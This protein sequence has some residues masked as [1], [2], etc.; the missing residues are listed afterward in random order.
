MPAENEGRP[1]SGP[2]PPR[3]HP[4]SRPPWPW[5]LVLLIVLAGT[6]QAFKLEIN[7]DALDLL[8]GEAVRGDIALLQQ[9]GLVDRLFITLSHD[10]THYPD[11]EAALSALKA[12]AVGV[13]EAMA[14]APLFT[15]VIYRFP[16]DFELALFQ[17]LEPHL[18]TLLHEEELAALAPRL[19]EEQLTRTLETNFARLNSP[20]GFILK[21]QVQRDPLGLMGLVLQKLSHL[22]SGFT[23]SISD[24]FFLSD[25][26]ASI[27]LLAEST[28]SLTDSS[29]AREVARRLTKIMEENLT[30][31]VEWRIIGS[32]PHT[33]A[34][35]D[36]VQRDLRLLLPVATVLLFS[37]LIFT[38]RDWRALL[39]LGIPFL[40]APAAIAVMGMIHG[41]VS[42]LALGFGI[43]LIGIAVDFAVH[44]Y[45]ALV[46]AEG[47][48]RQIKKLLLRPVALATLTTAGVFIILLFSEVPS[49]RQ[50]ASLS[51]S[52]ILLA[53]I[54]SWLLLPT[55]VGPGRI[56]PRPAPWFRVPN[57]PSLPGRFMA[58]ALWGSLLAAG[59]L[60]W[61]Q[62]TYNGDLQVLDAPDPKV[63]A[64]E[65]H[66]RA[67]W[68]E[69]GDQAF[70]VAAGS[71]LEQ[72]L[73]R[74]FIVYQ[75]LRQADSL[76]F[77]SLA[78]LLPG[79]A[80]QQRQL[81]A[82][83]EFWRS[84]SAEFLPRFDKAAAAAGFAPDAFKPFLK[85]LETAPTA[86]NPTRILQG[87]LQPL[88]ATMVRLPGPSTDGN[89][90]DILLLT[91]VAPAAAALPLLLALETEHPGITVL[92]NQKW[93]RQVEEL[94]RHDMVVLVS[95]AAILI[96]LLALL[97]FRKPRL[98]LA[99]LAPVLSALA[100]MIIFSRL[101]SGELNMMHLL[102]GIMVIGLSVDY[103]I[104]VV[105][106]RGGRLEG[107]TFLAVSI[108]AASS[109]LSFGVLAFAQH[110][111][112]HSLGVTVLCGI[113]LA[114]PT[115]LVISPILAGNGC[116]ES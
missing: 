2:P 109:L 14:A 30:A 77:Q 71:T 83:N 94:M 95:G 37:M 103:G 74:N 111:A 7:D 105:C 38:L 1:G 41:R 27:L 16:T 78:P 10:P 107:K 52:G 81:T 88:L 53:V 20:V 5:L 67:T 63:L 21:N 106:A 32:L 42:A 57:I 89:Q 12:S 61:P 90:P 15:E 35:A 50:M 18:P 76:Q 113:G 58:L 96:S 6:W 3:D 87:P 93:R 80:A 97:A 51:L 9:L 13:G 55:L 68:R 98:V 108:C 66:F 114:W 4:P 24:G 17:E 115:A 69:R 70:V 65:E 102:M 33:L 84:H 116:R 48:S 25:D 104:F 91:T 73:D 100:A 110:P 79:P 28:R 11:G 45:L 82:W 19:T 40:A 99:V 92:A 36:S 64:D 86:S 49:H 44:I 85:R 72:A 34:N 62:L 59:V 43:V 75:H 31:G 23:G 26:R 56:R 39:V 112:L 8:P 29:G 22:E 101:T 47:D 46:G 60:S 54:F